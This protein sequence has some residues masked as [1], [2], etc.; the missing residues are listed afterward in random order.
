MKILA[1]TIRSLNNA[2]NIKWRLTRDHQTDRGH[3]R[4]AVER[5]GASQVA[6][7]DSPRV[8]LSA[9]SSGREDRGEDAWACACI[10]FCCSVVYTSTHGLFSVEAN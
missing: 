10:G 1:A 4:D 5:C 6:R 9:H 3:E 8:G 2:P 7:R